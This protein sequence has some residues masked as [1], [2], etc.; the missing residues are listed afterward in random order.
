MKYPRCYCLCFDDDN[1][2]LVDCACGHRKHNGLCLPDDQKCKCIYNRY[3]NNDTSVAQGICDECVLLV[4]SIKYT[5]STDSDDECPICFEKN[6]FNVVLN[7]QH[8]VCHECWFSVVANSRRYNGNVI[9][10]CPLCRDEN[11]ILQCSG[12]DAH[13]ISGT[14][15]DICQFRISDFISKDNNGVLSLNNVDRRLKDKVVILAANLKDKTIENKRLEIEKSQLLNK[16]AI[17]ERS[18]SNIQIS[19]SDKDQY[20]MAV[21]KHKGM[22][23][24]YI[25]D[26]YQGYC[27]WV[28]G[29]DNVKG[30]MKNFKDYLLLFNI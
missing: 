24:K 21:G 30:A 10:R 11:N 16:I 15:C 6:I 27:L 18:S 13:L 29:L 8:K 2:P 26:N 12:C 7:C 25:K 22:T 4:G 19:H 3:C 1:N 5:I 20:R 14:L 28:L 23:F 9:R 17:L